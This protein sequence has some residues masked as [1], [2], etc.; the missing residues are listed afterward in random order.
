MKTPPFEEGK[1]CPTCRHQIYH[2][3]WTRDPRLLEQVTPG[4]SC[5]PVVL[6]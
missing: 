1:K 2:A 5:L 4:S 6:R 3:H